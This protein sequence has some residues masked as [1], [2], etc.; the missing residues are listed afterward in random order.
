MSILTE[1][2]LALARERLAGL[3]EPVELRLAG[4][5]GPGAV[6]QAYE[7]L[8]QLATD[9]AALS[10]LLSVSEGGQ[11]EL[12][13]ALELI[14]SEGQATGIRFVGLPLGQEFFVL[15]HDLVS[16]SRGT[17]SLSPLGRQSAK[18]LAGELLV[19]M[20]PG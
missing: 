4:G 16:V 20:T 19:F 3:V 10:P 2:L 12:G 5:G 11:A 14:D 1:S 8:R 6:G 15:L 17:T 7:G 9:L 13:P 18:E